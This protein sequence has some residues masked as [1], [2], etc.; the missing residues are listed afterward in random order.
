M[1]VENKLKEIIKYRV[2]NFLWKLFWKDD[3]EI[4]HS[5]VLERILYVLDSEQ[6]IR[7]IKQYVNTYLTKEEALKHIDIDSLIN[8]IP[9][10]RS[11]ENYSKKVTNSLI[12]YKITDMYKIFRSIELRAKNKDY[13]KGSEWIFDRDGNDISC[14]VIQKESI[15]LEEEDYGNVKYYVAKKSVGNLACIISNKSPYSLGNKIIKTT[16]LYVLD[17]FNLDE[18]TYNLIRKRYIEPLLETYKEYLE[19]EKLEAL[20]EKENN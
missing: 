3:D 11:N 1:I 15:V 17:D 12:G 16:N 19:N 6:N 10:D 4:V 7:L 9:L 14:R 5:F 2:K 13:C 20:K 18:E 8:K